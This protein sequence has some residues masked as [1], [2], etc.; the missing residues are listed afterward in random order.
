MESMTFANPTCAS[1]RY[2]L[3]SSEFLRF[4]GLVLA[5]LQG[6]L[7]HST[8]QAQTMAAELTTVR[9]VLALSEEAASAGT[10]TVRLRGIVTDVSA[11]QDECSLFDGEAGISLELGGAAQAPAQ[12]AEIQIEGRVISEP[13]LQRKRT[14]IKATKLTLLGA[15]TLPPAKPKP[16][17]VKEVAEFRQ[18]DQWVTVEG[19]VLQVR[20][21]MALFTIQI[22]SEA[23]SCNVLVRDWPR[24]AIPRDWIGGRVRVTGVNRAYLPGSSFLSL[25]ASSPDQVTVLKTGVIDPLDAPTTTVGA[26]RAGVTDKESRVKLAGTLLGATSGNVFY[27]RGTDGEA[28]SF[29]MLH[30]IDE[31]K[32]GRFST[33]II[34]PKCEPGDRLEV[35]GIPGVAGHGMHLNF[36]VVRVINSG[37]EP[38]AAPADIP[39]I[40]AGAHVHD[41]VEVHGRLLSLDDVLIAPGR[42]R[43]TLRLEHAGQRIIAFLD[44]P[45]RGALTHL[46][47]DHLLQ[48]HGIVTGEPHFPE[49]RLWVRTPDD[50][51]SH[52]MAKEVVARRLWIGLGIAG[53]TVILLAG[54]AL[55]LRRSRAAVTDLNATLE[56]RVAERTQ[57]LATAQEDLVRALSQERELSELKTRFVSLVSHEFRTPLG[58]TMSAVEVLRHYRERIDNEKHEELLED[59]HSATLQMSGL[60]EQ[61]L[62]LGRAE[63]GKLDWRPTQIDLP[64][65]CAKLVDEGLSAT[66]RRCPV[67]FTAQGDFSDALMDAALLR[68]ILGNLLS[69]AVKYSPERATVDFT[70]K[71]DGDEAV[72]VIQDHGI[73]IPEADQTRLYEAFHRA[74]NVGETPGTGLGLLLVK[75]CVELHHGSIHMQSQEGAGTTF[76]VR[77]PLRRA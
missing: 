23:T 44:A 16:A 7:L 41:L 68:H 39:T 9:A 4:A 30:P 26:L 29:Y 76:T 37:P 49:I 33:P 28:F 24:T 51:Q 71:R 62:L 69:N 3:R 50:L 11:Q 5:L 67:H 27:A 61:V 15:G 65:L 6:F 36:G 12:G 73:G 70:L 60:M 22:V 63:A 19:T 17:S 58:V 40:L 48:V 18:L 35:V 56:T 72:I 31:D 25:V 34:M 42:W 52:G 45:T 66:S 74:S 2:L 21:S 38:A 20:S 55:M 64:D 32:S 54:W 1:E 77:L 47:E 53:V 10:Q 13:F 57:A 46:G 75:R 43:T 14:C 8:L 59:I